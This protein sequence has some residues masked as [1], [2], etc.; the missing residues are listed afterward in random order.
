MEERRRNSRV[1][2]PEEVVWTCAGCGRK[3]RDPEN[4]TWD[5]WRSETACGRCEETKRVGVRS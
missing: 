5:E 3:L 1:K 4:C 2:M